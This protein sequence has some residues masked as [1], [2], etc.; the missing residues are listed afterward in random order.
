MEWARIPIERIYSRAQPRTIFEKLDELAE[1]LKELGQQQ[2]IVV[3]DDGQGGYLIEQGERRWRAAKIAGLESLYCVIRHE[4]INLEDKDRALRQLTENIQRDD[5]K[6]WELSQAVSGLVNS[7]IPIRELAKRLGKKESFISAL[8]AVATCPDELRQLAERQLIQDVQA[9]RR[10]QKIYDE[11]PAYVKKQVRRWFDK[12]KKLQ[13]ETG[14]SKSPFTISRL[15]V[16]EVYERMKRKT[17][18]GESKAEVPDEDSGE[19]AAQEEVAKGEWTDST[20]RDEEIEF[21]EAGD[22]A[23]EARPVEEPILTLPDGCTQIPTGKLR[24][25]VTWLGKK[26]YIV[27]NALPPAGKICIQVSNKENRLESPVM[28]NASDI[29]IV[30]VVQAA[31]ATTLYSSL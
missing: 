28:A 2:A 22:Q 18:A 16:E 1:S 12:A 31:G 14:S 13:E 19:V 10:L 20:E 11:N 23:D 8:N 30:Q 4:P 24:I 17:E 21:P 5:M 29:Q 9:M 3:T 15:Q 26:A 6:L 25:E 27:Q 7:G